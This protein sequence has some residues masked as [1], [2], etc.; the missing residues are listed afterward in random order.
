MA[1][2][3]FYK[4]DFRFTLFNLPVDHL[5]ALYSLFSI[6]FKTVELRQCVYNDALCTM[7]Q[8]YAL[9]TWTITETRRNMFEL[10]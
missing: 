6:E 5:Q 8:G 4:I 2:V 10:N 9:C 3:K 1:T 7:M